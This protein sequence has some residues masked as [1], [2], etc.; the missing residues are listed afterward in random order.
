MLVN[1]DQP[2]FTT[3]FRKRVNFQ[4]FFWLI[5]DVIAKKFLR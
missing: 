4:L 3:M 5:S 1:L 2:T